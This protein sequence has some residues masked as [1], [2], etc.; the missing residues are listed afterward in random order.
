MNGTR[1][2]LR[3]QLRRRWAAIAV[4]AVMVALGTG[5]AFISLGAAQRTKDAY[6]DHLRRAD[7]GDVV[8]NPSLATTDSDDLIRSLPGVRRVTR[9]V[10]LDA[11]MDDGHTRTRLELDT[12]DAFVE[13]RGSSDG[14]YT[15]MDRPAFAE[16]RAIRRADETLVTKD[17]ARSY[18]VH[19]GDVI[20][21]AFWDSHDDS[22]EPLE[23]VMD[24]VGVEHL[25][26]VGIVTLADE[27]LPDGLYPRGRIIVSPEVTKRYDCLPPPPSPDADF[28]E[29]TST[30]APPGCATSYPYYSL[31][32]V[33]GRKGVAAAAHAF[34]SGAAELNAGLPAVMS[35]NDVLYDLLTITTAQQQARV[36]RSLQPAVIT[37]VV[38]G[39]GAA[40]VTLMVLGLAVAR[41]LRRSEDEQLQWWRMG[42]TSSQ[43]LVVVL[44]P[45]VLGA[46]LGMVGGLVLAWGL[47]TIAPVGSV[48]SL[49]PSPSRVLAGWAM[50][51]A[52]V[53][54]VLAGLALVLLGVRATRRLGR[55]SA[56]AS[57]PRLLARLVRRSGRPE[58]T[59]GIRAAF[60][61]RG[62]GLVIASGGVAAAVLLAAVVFGTSLSSMVSTPASYGWPWDAA[63]MGGFGYGR[64]DLDALKATMAD[65][66]EVR[67]WSLLGFG[68]FTIDGRSAVGMVGLGPPAHL[69]LTVTHG[70]L[71]RGTHEVALGARTASAAHVGVGDTVTV[72]GPE[73]EPGPLT[74][75]GIVVLPAIG[76]YQADRAEPGTGIVLPPDLFD[77]EVLAREMTFLGM[78]LAPGSEPEAF[79][80]S[81]RPEA[82]A[83]A[84]E[85]D[86]PFTYPEAVRPPEVVNAASMRSVPLLV[87][88]LLAIAAAAGLAFAVG[89]SVRSRR[90]ELGTLRALGFTRLQLR[91]TVLVQS[92]ATTVTTLVI[93]VPLGLAA[94]RVA[95]R[96]F[97]ERLGVGTEPSLSVAWL[98]GSIVGGLLVGVGAAALPS[99]SAAR[100]DASAVLR[101]DG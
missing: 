87:G 94:G 60:V 99:W 92:L 55:P 2:L 19:V 56:R 36:E 95:W 15:R 23:T 18:D 8:M 75:S 58:L 24:P 5:G 25:R 48:R 11:T 28:D 76:P 21:V 33:D 10:L 77:A 14:R 40:L 1:W 91:S 88:A 66:S 39:L 73:L 50:L 71:P 67:S 78:D 22:F 80:A 64:Q 81:L 70:R 3:Y 82:Q 43:R 27:V 90:R 85:G 84:V 89:M 29:A 13:V 26:V 17:L 65:R 6:T 96:L 38:L 68:T 59:E 46:A 100:A 37:L 101:P 7:V 44:A 42:M 20:P 98:V 93:G 41:D 72:A 57:A 61:S 52:G 31:D 51:A 32:L 74:V 49:D 4:L 45:P 63:V 62:S 16:G 35:D 69:D 47:S 34:D 79:M 54:V 86:F 12:G 83:W 53:L 9:D 97:A 30:L